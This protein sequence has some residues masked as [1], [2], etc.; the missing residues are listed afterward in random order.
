[1]ISNAE[2]IAF[3][4]DVGVHDLVVEVLTR[5]GRSGDPPGVK[6]HEPAEETELLIHSKD[7][8]GGEVG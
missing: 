1:M 8:N 6:V 5:F 4:F 3:R 7:S 2:V